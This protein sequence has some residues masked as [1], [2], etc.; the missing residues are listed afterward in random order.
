MSVWWAVISS[1]R[2]SG[3]V[4]VSFQQMGGGTERTIRDVIPDTQQRTRNEIITLQF[5]QPPKEGPSERRWALGGE[6]PDA[7]CRAEGSETG[8]QACFDPS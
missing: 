2:E 7:R 8:H 4:C 1:A 5:I 6:E 3:G